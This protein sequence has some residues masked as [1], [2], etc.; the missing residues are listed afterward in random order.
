[1]VRCCAAKL[2]RLKIFYG[3]RIVAASVG[4]QT[5]HACLLLQAF[6]AYVAVLS[7]EQGWSKTALSGAAALL[8]VEGAVLGPLLGYLA[9]RVGPRAMVRTGVVL[10]ALGFLALSFTHSI[11]H[12]Y[13]SV[14]LIA[15]STSFCGYFPLSVAVVHWFRK[16]RARALSLTSLG[17]AFGGLAVPAVGWVMQTYGWR[18]MALLSAV[19]WLTL[20][21]LLASVVRGKPSDVGETV[22][23]EPVPEPELVT[24]A[25]AAAATAVPERAFTAAE[26]L[27]TR[28]F[29]LLGLGHAI[30]LLAVTAVNVHAISH[31][32]EG[33]GYTLA[34]A[35]FVITLMTVS[36]GCGVLLGAAVGDR[37]DKRRVAAGC[38]VLHMAGLLMLTYA[39]H[40]LM[41]G[42][43][44]VLHGVAWGLRGPFMQALRADYFGLQSIGMILGLSAILISLGQI[45]GPLVA[46]GFADLTGNYRFGFTLLA[47]VVGAGSLLFL[48]ARKPA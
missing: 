5:L 26:A 4:I 42:A 18:T 16:R 44:A 8:S 45:G 14:L 7:E 10:V 28:A 34:Q 2:R 29:W 32:K 25:S 22:D 12:F 46:G 9:D 21:S 36:Q 31:M 19:L 15:L 41:L 11:T 6:G 33:L 23:G 24:G 35:S 1:V 40:P 30:A 47:L 13:G 39:V 20:G 38:M 48:L 17:L 27:R 37:W 3:W 43:F